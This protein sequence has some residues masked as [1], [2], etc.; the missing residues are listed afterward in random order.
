MPDHPGRACPGP[1]DYSFPSDHA[2]IAAALAAGLWLANRK[3]GAI[4]AVLALVEGFSRVYLGL[5]YPHD[6]AAGILLSMVVLFG[7]WPFVRRPFEQVLAKRR[8]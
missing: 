1:T 6:I 8:P 3:V 4:A 7:G 5:H 2:T